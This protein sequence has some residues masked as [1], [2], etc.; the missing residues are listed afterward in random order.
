M[1]RP[2]TLCSLLAVASA[3][4]LCGP[5]PVRAVSPP[6]SF[7]PIVRA[8]GPAVAY[9]FTTQAR[10][11]RRFG[12]PGDPFDDF[13]QRFFGDEM[14]QVRPQQSLGSGFIISADG[15]IVTN[16]HVIADAVSIR[17]RLHDKRE[18]EAELVGSDAKTDVALIKVDGTHLPTVKLGHSAGLEIG[19]WVL[20]IGNP[21]GL[22]QTVTA[23][24]VSAKGR[25]IGA[26]PYDDFIQTDAS[27]NPGNSGGPLLDS[28]GEVVG[29]NS[30]IFSRSGGNIGIGFAIPID[31]AQHVIAQLREHG[32]VIRGWLG[33]ET[34][35]ITPELARSFGLPQASGALV[36]QV[37]PGGP[38]GEAGMR[39]GDVVIAYAGKPVADSRGLRSLIADAPIDEQVTLRIVRDG[40]QYSVRAKVSGIPGEAARQTRRSGEGGW[41]F[42]VSE[43]TP[44]LARR[45]GIPPGVRG[46]M[47]TGVTEG[48][49]AAAAGVAEGDVI[50]EVNR[51]AVTSVAQLQAA[52]RHTGEQLL[53]LIQRGRGAGFLLL[54]R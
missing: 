36:V 32:R 38:A 20:A 44:L 24:I 14:P 11:M 3:A 1:R 34:Q 10:R 31:L 40:R 37:A 22:E 25:V 9:I 41:G 46:V 28:D 19:D 12:M 48:G 53:L 45:A 18:Y 42:E 27:I 21:F 54:Q 7:A 50:R 16:A 26:G 39:R 5:P 47:V 43:L 35:D 30:A 6:E 13:F 15:Y 8:A 23:G 51:R 29:I 17:V 49:S 33:L 52:V 4:L 2:A